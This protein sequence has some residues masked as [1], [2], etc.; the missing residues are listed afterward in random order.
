[1]RTCLALPFQHIRQ[2][3]QEAIHRAHVAMLGG[4]LDDSVNW[5]D[6]RVIGV[7]FFETDVGTV[8]WRVIIAEASPT[9][10]KFRDYVSAYLASQHLS[11]VEV[12]T[13][14]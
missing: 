6:L 9:A 7:E 4:E 1:M 5:A 11:E 2:H 10:T 12:V 3:T 13:E 14:W 8:G